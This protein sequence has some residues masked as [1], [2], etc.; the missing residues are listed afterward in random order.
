[1]PSY[2]DCKER[3]HEE[4]NRDDITNHVGDVHDG[5]WFGRGV[6]FDVDL[7][8]DEDRKMQN[9]GGG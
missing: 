6:R 3:I 4:L 1:V 9:V 2:R 5:C 7:M 8:E